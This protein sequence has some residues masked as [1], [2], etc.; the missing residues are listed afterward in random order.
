MTFS[1]AY[2]YPIDFPEAQYYGTARYPGNTVFA[3]TTGNIIPNEYGLLAR[4]GVGVVAGFVAYLLARKLKSNMAKGL[5]GVGGFGLGFLATGFIVA[6]KVVVDNKAPSKQP[7]AVTQQPTAQLPQPQT[8][9]V[10]GAGFTA[11]PAQGQSAD[12]IARNSQQQGQQQQAQQQGS[13]QPVQV[14]PVQQQQQASQQQ[15]QASQQ[16]INN[17]K[18][19][20]DQ[21]G[22]NQQGAAIVRRRLQ[23][24]QTPIT[25]QEY[26]QLVAVLL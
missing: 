16:Y 14:Q 5:I 12:V 22:I 15:T 18:Q 7:Q 1:P 11:V 17:L 20:L 24:S 25:D 4:S 10:P 21:Q 26:A 3:N 13:Q 19:L 9:P 6:P 23:S 2:A 8:P